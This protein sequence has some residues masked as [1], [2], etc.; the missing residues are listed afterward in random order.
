MKYVLISGYRLR[1][2]EIRVGNDSELRNNTICHKQV[3]SVGDGLTQS[4]QCYE[5]LYGTWV[6]VNKS[7]IG[8]DNEFLQLR[9][10]RVFGS[11][12][13]IN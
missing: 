12:Y 2:F 4:F 3:K 1:K 9:E 11:E 6:S 8:M 13:G 7:D 10:V 5:A